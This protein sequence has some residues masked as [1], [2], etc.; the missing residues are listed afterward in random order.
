MEFA[1]Q[2]LDAI[3]KAY[4]CRES[5]ELYVEFESLIVVSNGDMF[6]STRIKQL[7]EFASEYGYEYFISG[8]F[9]DKRP[10]WIF[11]KPKEQ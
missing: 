9:T 3:L 11:Y 7:V 6:T 5:F 1:K 4:G 2:L 10:R 8:G